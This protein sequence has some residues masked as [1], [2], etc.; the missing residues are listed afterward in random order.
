MVW[1]KISSLH[2]PFDS[3]ALSSPGTQVEAEHQADRLWLTPPT[4]D[5]LFQFFH[6]QLALSTGPRPLYSTL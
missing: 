1:V 3:W 2:G 4:M 5:K 6:L